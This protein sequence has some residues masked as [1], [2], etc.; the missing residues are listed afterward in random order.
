M[1]I[2]FLFHCFDATQIM[3]YGY[4]S[5]RQFYLVYAVRVVYSI[6]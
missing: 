2:L 6:G 3:L 1:F 5:N 4:K